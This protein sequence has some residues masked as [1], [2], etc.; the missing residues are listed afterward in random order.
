M[1]KTTR[2]K[3]LGWLFATTAV[4][5]AVVLAKQIPAE[6]PAAK[7]V[8]RVR[9]PPDF[10]FIDYERAEWEEMRSY[11]ERRLLVGR[12]WR[13]SWWMHW[14]EIAANNYPERYH[15]LGRPIPGGM[16]KDQPISI[17]PDRVTYVPNPLEA[18]R[19]LSDD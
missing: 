5:A 12:N 4:P 13:T 1:L 15:W 6:A 14:S 3:I 8:I 9:L 17:L 10:K 19:K 11:L 2:R 7:Q 16:L 18:L